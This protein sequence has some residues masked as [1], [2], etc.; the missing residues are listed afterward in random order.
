MVS[1]ERGPF[2]LD[3]P[4]EELQDDA[5]CITIEQLQQLVRLVDQS[6]TLE[7]EVRNGGT[8]A[9]LVLR[10]SRPQEGNIAS[11]EALAPTEEAAEQPHY[12]ITAPYVGLFEPWSR[13]QDRPLVAVG[14]LVQVGQHVGAIRSMGIPNEVESPVTGRVVEILVQDGQPV[15]YGQPLMTCSILKADQ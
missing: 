10:K 11:G 14:D 2:I 8:K 15:E 7:L 5:E 12:T 3:I 9:H 4:V 13:S 6:D 1:N